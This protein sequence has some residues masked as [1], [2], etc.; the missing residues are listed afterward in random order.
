MDVGSGTPTKNTHLHLTHP[1]H[2]EQHSISALFQSRSSTEYPQE[3]CVVPPEVKCPSVINLFLSYLVFFFFFFSVIEYS[4][5]S[6]III[7]FIR[8][9]IHTWLGCFLGGPKTSIQDGLGTWG[10]RDGFVWDRSCKGNRRRVVG[11]GAA[12]CRN[13]HSV[14]PRRKAI[15]FQPPQSECCPVSV[16]LI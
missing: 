1:S 5:L 9:N 4:S 11:K 13:G 15:Y 8:S 2:T 16:L 7:T 6:H 14:I 3:T 10:V 12:L